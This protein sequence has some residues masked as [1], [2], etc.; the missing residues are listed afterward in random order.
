MADLYPF[1][2]ATPE[3]VGIASA[4]IQDFLDIIDEKRVNLHGFM[5]VRNGKCAAEGY[6]AP[7]NEDYIHRMYSCSK[8]F[9][10][11]AIGILI[12]DGRIGL[13]DPI[14]DYFPEYRPADPHPYQ[15]SMTIRDLLM[16]ATPYAEGSYE[17]SDPDWTWTFFNKNKPT[18]PGGT[19]WHYDTSGTHTMSA[20][21]EKLTGMKLMDFLYER[22]FRYMGGSDDMW[23][24]S[25]PEGYSWGGSGVLARQ[26]DLARLGYLWL[27]NGRFNGMQ[28]VPEWYIKEASSKQIDNELLG[29]HGRRDRIGYGYQVWMEPDGGF[30]FWGLATQYMLA[31]REKGLMLVTT[32]DTLSRG[33]DESIVQEAFSEC[34]LKRLSDEALPEDEAAQKALE[35]RLA[36][37]EVYLPVGETDS[38][39]REKIDGKTYALCE[40][41]MGMKTVRFDFAPDGSDGVISWENEQGKKCVRFGMGR[42]IEGRFPQWGYAYDVIA[43]P[44]DYLYRTLNAGCW[45]EPHKL[46]L[47]MFIE[48]VQCGLITWKIAFIDEGN[49]VAMM[50]CKTGENILWEYWGNCS[51][52][53]LVD[54]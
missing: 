4:W 46:E 51:G 35:A 12:G 42:Y 8:S 21:V 24:I 14:I 36:G 17:F 6:W 31:Y 18:H 28:L 27:N 26:R 49:T 10:S 20:L 38:A 48:D 11:T 37:L 43:K 25:A 44:T 34:I 50:L 1:V 3:S 15:L 47:S 33:S 9:T 29:L 2:K 32:G 23:C 53:R 13:N 30:S 19:I 5:I 16:M 22:V 41:R 7:F 52:E 45:V 54:N 39:W 40:N